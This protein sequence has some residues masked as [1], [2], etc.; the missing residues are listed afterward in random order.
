MLAEKLIRLGAKVTLLLG[1]VSAC[2]ISKKIRLIRF[3]FFDELKKRLICEVKTG[4]YDC[5]I[6]SAAV[7]DYRLKR[8]LVSKVCSDKKN[9]RL[10][11]VPN[12]KIIDGVKRAD[13]S[14]VLAGFKYEPGVDRTRL[15]KEAKKLIK[16]TEAD[17][18]VANTARGRRYCAYLVSKDKVS[19]P[20]TGKD[21]MAES[22]IRQIGAALCRD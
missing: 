22:L 16:R 12:E 6:L 19:G 18:I 10:D 2:C 4:K 9:W 14:L 7:S 20:W 11:L 5:L 21:I 15:L 8:P 13:R 17:M 1:P 3:R